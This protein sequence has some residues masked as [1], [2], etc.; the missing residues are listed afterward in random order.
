MLCFLSVS[1]LDLQTG[2]SGASIFVS[3]A[4]DYGTIQVAKYS[5]GM[6]L[7]CAHFVEWKCS[8]RDCMSWLHTTGCLWMF[9]RMVLSTR[10]LTVF[11]ALLLTSGSAERHQLM[12]LH[13]RTFEWWM[14]CLPGVNKNF[15]ILVKQQEMR[16]L[17]SVTK[18]KNI[19][20]WIFIVRVSFQFRN[21]KRHA[22]HSTEWSVHILPNYS[23][24]PFY[25]LSGVLLGGV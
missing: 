24:A 21:V 15:L 13:L 6:F 7:K 4:V 25:S 17:C 8:Q 10:R 3:F 14:S 11:T 16:L 5:E 22:N 2:T 9:G 23:I 12:D 20:N 19:I 18:H 1:Q